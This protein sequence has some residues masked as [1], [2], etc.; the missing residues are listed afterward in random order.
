[1]AY[2]RT[3]P[4]TYAEAHHIPQQQAYAGISDLPF[5]ILLVISDYLR[6]SDVVSLGCVS[7][8]LLA[9]C[10]RHCD[11]RRVPEDIQD[12]LIALRQCQGFEQR[13]RRT[14]ELEEAMKVANV[15]DSVV[16]SWDTSLGK[17][18]YRSGSWAAWTVIFRSHTKMP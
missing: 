13:K 11:I 3:P 10:K 17:G 15:S 12:R 1:M 16:R 7:E 4:P 2:H 5:E 8:R 6:L 18:Q 14:I 9:V